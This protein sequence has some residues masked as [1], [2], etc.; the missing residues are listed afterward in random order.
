MV[1]LSQLV[2][3][4]LSKVRSEMGG[5]GGGLHSR[6]VASH[7]SP[8]RILFR[9]KIIYVAE[10]NQ[11]LWLEESGQSLENVD[12]THLV[13]ASGK[14]LVATKRLFSTYRPDLSLL[15]RVSDELR[16]PSPFPGPT[17]TARRP[18]RPTRT[19][20]RLSSARSRPPSSAEPTL[21]ES[22]RFDLF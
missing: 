7:F 12:Q 10:F 9:E 17:F 19:R 15:Q 18:A 22:Q 14:W 5:G 21:S 1:S 6:E 3:G 20:P 4:M 16:N 8:S 13:L 2:F 11:Q